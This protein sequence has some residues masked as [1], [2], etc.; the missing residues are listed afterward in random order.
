M[1]KLTLV[2]DR[3]T[4][5]IYDIDQPVIKIGRVQGMDIQIDHVSVSRRQAEICRDGEAWVVRDIGSSNGTFVNGERL[6]GDRPLKAGDEISIGQYSLFFERGLASFQPRRRET[7]E[8]RREVV[9]PPE[10]PPTGP[11]DAT[12]YLKPEEIEKLQVE[13]S[14]KRQAHLVWEIR[15][16]AP[17]THYLGQAGGAVIGRSKLCDLRVPAGSRH[18]LLVIRAAQG[19]EARNLSFWRRMKVNGRATRRIALRNR[20]IIEMGRLRV[21]F[22]AGEG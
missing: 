10:P 19:Y 3:K 6:T 9:K 15:G 5:E 21:T 22:L 17:S 8:A 11:R 7:G 4:V 13:A 14:Q 20:D 2:H 18:H 16:G 12:M 1:P